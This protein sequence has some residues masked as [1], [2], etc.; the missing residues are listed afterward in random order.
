MISSL[1]HLCTTKGA[2]TMI[3][4]RLGDT[5]DARRYLDATLDHLEQFAHSGLRTL[6]LA[7]KD[8]G[9]AQYENWNKIYQASI[10]CQ[11]ILS[12]FEVQKEVPLFQLRC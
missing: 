7:M 3:F 2:D 11:V 4:E 8:I 5:P 10:E 9:S 1:T 6:C 12:I